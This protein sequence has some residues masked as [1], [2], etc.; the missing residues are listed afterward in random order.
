MKKKFSKAAGSLVIASLLASVIGCSNSGTSNDPANNTGNSTGGNNTGAVSTEPMTL[1]AFF[2]DPNTTWNNMQ[3][4]VGKYITEKTGITLKPEF[5]VGDPEQKINLIAASGEYPDL[6]SPKGTSGALIDAG[7]L[8][9]LT[10]LIEEHAPNIKAMLGDQINRLR[11]S[12]EDPSIYFIPSLEAIDQYYF[13]AGGPFNLQHE[14]VKEL[15]YPKMRT[16]KDYEN[17][18]KAYKEKHP[19]IDGQPT[20]GLSLLADDWRIMISTTNPAFW[21][22]GAPDDGE[23][24]IDPE[25]YEAILHYK[26]PE[27]REYFRW[28]NHMNDIGLLD[29]ESFVQKYDQYKAKIAS[30]RVLA[31]IDQQWEIDEP[32]ATLKAAGKHERTYGHYP[33]TLDETYKAANFQQTGFNGGWGLGITTAAEDPVRIIKFLDWLASEEGQILINWGI[34]GKHYEYVDGKRVF[35]P[36]IQDIRVNDNNRFKKEFGIGNYNLSLRYGDGVKDSTGNYYTTNNPEQVLEAYSD[37]EKEVL[38]GYGATYWKDLFPQEDEF[39]VKPWGAAWNIPVPTD[40]VI[41]VTQQKANDI[42]RKRIP[43][44]IL[45]K[46]ADFDKV[47]DTMLA[48]LDKAGVKKMEEEYTELVRARVELWSGQ[49]TK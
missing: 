24:Y 4:D 47:Y 9:D 1:T 8:L 35:L 39:E 48:E 37:V 29:K 20:I 49:V 33:I 6:I 3:D 17:A 2:P 7:A 44:A 12:N 34:E 18:I 45:A 5:A 30:G 13:D 27:E 32:E 19:T 46:P 40:S 23:F 42:V 28:L 21:A 41:P 31:T 22:T 10:D 36:E 26:R 43:E 14:V 11:Y 16:L 25:T 15:G 38:A